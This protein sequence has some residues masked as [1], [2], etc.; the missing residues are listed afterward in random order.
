MRLFSVYHFDMNKYYNFLGHWRDHAN[1]GVEI[2]GPRFPQDYKHVADVV[3]S[4]V[5]K[6]FE[7]TNHIDHNWEDNHGVKPIQVGNRSTSVGD[8]VVDT[9]AK[10]KFLCESAGW[11]EEKING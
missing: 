2:N 5:D 3:A 6:V 4:D 7:L 10:I 11:S 8:I 9:D 1:P